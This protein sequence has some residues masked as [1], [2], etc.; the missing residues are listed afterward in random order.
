[1]TALLTPLQVG[2][3]TLRNRVVVTSH[4]TCY[5]DERHH[6]DAR[7]VAYYAARAAGGAA[8]LTTGT[9]AVHPSSPLPYGVYA[10]F[11]DSIIEPYRVL[12]DAVHEHGALILPQLGHMAQR[13]YSEPL[14]T[15]SPGSA[16]Y[17]TR[18]SAPHAMS[19]EEV[20]ELV[21]AFAAAA[22]RSILGGMDGV[23]IACGHGQLINLFLSPLTNDRSDEYGGDLGGRL[24]FAI[25]VVGA[26]REAIGPDHILGVR[27]N[28]DDQVTG[29]LDAPEWELICAALSATGNVDY[30]NVSANFHE[31]V[32]P[33]MYEPPG[34]YLAWATAIRR[35]VDVPVFCVGRIVDPAY[36]NQIVES[37]GADAVGMVRAH[38]ADPDLVN[39]YAAGSAEDIRPCVGCVQTCIG[40]VQ[41]G[42]PIT[43]IFNPQ[44]GRE[45]ERTRRPAGAEPRTVVVVGGGPGG[46]EAARAAAEAGM[47]V[48]L[49]EQASF[50]GG[51]ARR[52]TA[53]IRGRKEFRLGTEWAERQVTRLAVDV[54]LSTTARAESI[55]AER[56]DLVI[57]AT[58]AADFVPSFGEGFSHVIGA[59]AALDRPDVQGRVLIIDGEHHGQALFVA[60]EMSARGCDITI[61]TVEP[62]I[63][64]F[65]ERNMRDALF[66][67]LEGKADY[68]SLQRWVGIAGDSVRP[69]AQFEHV[70]TLSLSEHAADWIV[71]T[72]SVSCESLVA[73][74]RPHAE[75]VAIGDA[76]APRRIESAVH[77][78]WKAVSDWTAARRE[79]LA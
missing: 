71:G 28:G 3:R 52:Y 50:L 42:K 12:T 58:G 61:A 8:L 13:A 43:C 74:L 44:T 40:N 63:G 33:T 22:R 34:V 1:M 78:A 7:D 30:I 32:V 11:D 68:L 47:R 79:V 59:R 49:F 29:S 69:V 20:R 41:E 60:D 48:A 76:L 10:N 62:A 21:E 46:M 23:E 37:G 2:P 73:D 64:G 19:G 56:P 45:V 53:A 72:G 36:A 31:S 65:L 25:E 55:I 14:S 35:R 39:K 75:V 27:V 57:V 4:T 51:A 54:R 70:S 9:V 67:R 17:H 77:E 15:W 38:I 6:P 24:R 18:G 26:V 5:L 66:R 16:S